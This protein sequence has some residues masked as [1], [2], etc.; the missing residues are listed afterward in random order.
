M[1]SRLVGALGGKI[2][3]IITTSMIPPLKT[4][5]LMQELIINDTLTSMV[6]TKK[7]TRVWPLSFL[8]LKTFMKHFFNYF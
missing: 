5:C 6:D 3:F 4:K 8:D 7:E 1:T 2:R